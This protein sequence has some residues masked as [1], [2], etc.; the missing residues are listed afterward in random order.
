MKFWR[1]ATGDGAPAD[2]PEQ[3]TTAGRARTPGSAR[4]ARLRGRS[5]DRLVLAIHLVG[6]GVTGVIELARLLGDLTPGAFALGA[7][8]AGASGLTALFVHGIPPETVGGLV[9]VGF[10]ALAASRRG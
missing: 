2:F 3:P 9:V 7:A 4:P 5:G 6:A 1:W 10:I 8:L